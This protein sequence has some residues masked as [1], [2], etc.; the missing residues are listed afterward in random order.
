[1][2]A[3]ASLEGALMVVPNFVFYSVGSV[4]FEVCY[5]TVF[6]GSLWIAVSSNGFD[7]GK[8]RNDQ[9]DGYIEDARNMANDLKSARDQL[10]GDL[11]Q[12]KAELVKLSDEQR[13]AAGLA[14]VERSGVTGALVKAAF[15]QQ[16][17]MNWGNALPPK[18]QLIHAELFGGKQQQLVDTRNQLT[19]LDQ[20]IQ[21][22]IADLNNF[23]P[24]VVD[25][26]KN[27]EE[28]IVGELPSV[29]E[30]GSMKDPF[31]SM[32]TKVVKSKNGQNVTITI[33]FQIDESEA[34]SQR[35]RLNNVREDFAKYQ[36]EFI[37][38]AGII[39]GS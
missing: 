4:D 29:R 17:D 20:D 22:G 33:G 26:L 7:G 14:L 16:E 24:T 35:D 13:Q 15:R 3:K 32:Q 2:G 37:E 1:M 30:I 6:K 34:Q 36:D 31:R 10:E 18:L 19:K 38:Q 27:Y 12:A 28:L 11:E 23:Q 21:N 5:V 25:E 9:Y 39:Y 8:G